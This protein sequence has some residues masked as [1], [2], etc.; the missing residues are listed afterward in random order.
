MLRFLAVKRVKMKKV[1]GADDASF[2]RPQA[3]LN[4]R[5]DDSV[6]E[7]SLPPLEFEGGRTR[8][9]P[10]GD[11]G[12]VHEV[13]RAEHVELVVHQTHLVG[14]VVVIIGGHVMYDVCNFLDF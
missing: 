6:A 7:V 10:L 1:L 11:A 14:L 5:H 3:I 12:L 13:R 4:F 2:L 8:R 9:R